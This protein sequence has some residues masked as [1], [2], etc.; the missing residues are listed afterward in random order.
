MAWKRKGEELKISSFVISWF[1][2]RGTILLIGSLKLKIYKFP[3]EIRTLK[4]PLK[5]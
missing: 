2:L 3:Q 4:M 1:R 5:R